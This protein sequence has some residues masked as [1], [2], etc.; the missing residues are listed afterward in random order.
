MGPSWGHLGASWGL[1]GAS[2]G[3]LRG[4]RSNKR[5]ALIRVPPSKGQNGAK[6]IVKPIVGFLAEAVLDAQT[7]RDTPCPGPGEGEWGG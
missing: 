4:D 7:P 1:L 3:H 5:G 2:W 6:T